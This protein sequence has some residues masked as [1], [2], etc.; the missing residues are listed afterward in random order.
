MIWV[1]SVT[2]GYMNNK[3]SECKMINHKTWY[4]YRE[5]HAIG[6]NSALC[7]TLSK[8]I[9]TCWCLMS[10]QIVGFFMEKYM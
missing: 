3:P 7:Q 2:K 9:S 4:M 5:V 1:K 10:I 6:N 8:I